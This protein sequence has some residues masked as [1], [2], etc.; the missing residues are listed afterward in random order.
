MCPFGASYL[1][2]GAKCQLILRR[3]RLRNILSPWLR[4]RELFA[5]LQLELI[6]HDPLGLR[7][8]LRGVVVQSQ[9]RQK[10]AGAQ[11]RGRLIQHAFEGTC[12]LSEGPL[13]ARNDGT[14]LGPNVISLAQRMEHED[15]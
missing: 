7:E 15:I 9:K 10:A 11:Q 12:Q 8:A 5:Y 3:G 13:H 1:S 4:D 2:R 6:L 14:V